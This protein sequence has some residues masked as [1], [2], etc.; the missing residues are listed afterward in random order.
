MAA[1]NAVHVDSSNIDQLRAWDGDE[2]E[3]WVDHAEYFDRSI[4][5]H[6]ERLLAVAA[7]GD[8]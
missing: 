3:Y 6:H 8:A 4:A 7:I 2:G 1:A 5:A